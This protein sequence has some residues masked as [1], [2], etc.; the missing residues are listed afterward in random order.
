LKQPLRDL[1]DLCALGGE[2]SLNGSSSSLQQIIKNPKATTSQDMLSEILQG[3]ETV[4]QKHS[5]SVILSAHPKDEKD[6]PGA[7]ASS[8]TGH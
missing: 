3:L 1:C 2:F 4:G 6:G 5:M 7:L 8:S